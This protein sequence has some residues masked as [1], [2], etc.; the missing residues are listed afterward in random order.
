MENL[1]SGPLEVSLGVY[2]L[3]YKGQ[4]SK[5]QPLWLSC[6]F[7]SND[8]NYSSLGKQSTQASR[9]RQ[10]RKRDAKVEHMKL[11][12]QNSSPFKNVN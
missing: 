6:H 1:K 11:A 2:M 10:V 4:S 8:S 9:K 3:W 12:S 7:I 5:G